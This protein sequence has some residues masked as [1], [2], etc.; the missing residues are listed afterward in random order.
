M[1]WPTH[2]GQKRLFCE[3]FSILV[4]S[5]S[6]EF[7]MVSVRGGYYSVGKEF[8]DGLFVFL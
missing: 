8:S 1:L 3:Y 5:C 2:T 4:L 7:E 6:F